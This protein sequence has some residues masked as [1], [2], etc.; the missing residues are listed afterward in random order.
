[1]RCSTL[2][3]LGALL[4]CALVYTM[5]G[6]PS[7]RAQAVGAIVGAVTD[8]TGAVIVGAKVNAVN[9]GTNA[10]SSTQTDGVGRYV[11]DHLNP[12]VYSLEITAA[13][14]G[15]FKH[16]H[17]I[18]EVGR[19]T[20]IEATLK[21]A[22][23]ESTVTTTAEAP[24]VQ[25]DRSDF[26]TNI[27]AATM[28]NSAVNAR[29]WST[30]ALGTPGASP[31]GT[32]GLISFRGISGLLNNNTVDGGDNNQAFF[33]EE[34][35]R[36]RISYSISSAAIQEFQVNTSNYS[37]EYGRAAGG[38]VNAVTK[39]GTNS[40]HGEA[41]WYYRDSDIGATNPFTTQTIL[42]NGVN[43][44]VPIKPPDRR[45]QFGG[46][47]G[48][49]IFK[50]KLFFFF[51]ADQQLRNF[52]G[53]AAPSNPG[54]FFAPLSSSEVSTLTSRGITAAQGN[55]V[56]TGFLNTL[57]GNV[58]RKGDELLLFPKLD[59]NINEKNHA[60][61]EYNR[62]RWSSPAGIQTA[63]V[64]FRGVES[65]GDDFVKID[66]LVARLS[67]TLSP[68]MVNEFR[69]SY[70]RDF[71]YE[72]SQPSIAGEPVSQFGVSPQIS[73]F[74]ASGFTFGKPNFLDRA[75][76]PD[77]RSV[78][79]ADT[80]S[81]SRGRHLF[82]FG[83]D[84]RHTDDLLDN[85]FQNAGV[86]NYNNRVDYISDYIAFTTSHAPFC[87][88]TGCYSSFNQAFGPSAFEFATWDVGF[89]AN[90]DWRVSPRLTLTLGLRYDYQKFPSPQVP[91]TNLPAS[92]QF[93]SDTLNFGPRVGLAWNIT[94]DGKTVLRGGYGITYG[95]VINSTISNAITNTGNTAGQLQF[96]FS[97]PT[98]ANAPVYPNVVPTAPPP[99]AAPPDVV[100]FAPDT[101][102]PM[103]HEFD[104][105][106]EREIARNTAVSV[107]Y[108]GSLG[109]HLPLF[110]D[111]NLPAPASTITYKVLGGPSDQQMFT[112][113]LF[114][115]SRP[116]VGV[117]ASFGR[118]T[119]ISDIVSSRY[120]ALAFQFTRRMTHGLQVQAQYTYSHAHDNG[121]SSQ[122]FT[123]PNNVF[124]PYDLGLEEGRSNF[125]V[126]NHFA[127]SAIWQPEIV[128]SDSKVMKLLA[129]GFTFSPTFSASSGF[130]YTG[131]V[132]GNAPLGGISTG[133]IRAGG[134]ARVPFEP[135]N[136][137]QSPGSFN[138]DFR[139]G[140]KFAITERASFELLTDFFNLL[141][142]VNPTSLNG[143][144]GGSG[145]EY[146]T[147][148]CTAAIT[149]CGTYTGPALQYQSSFG[150]INNTSSSLG[151]PGQ[152]QIQIGARLTW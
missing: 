134:T 21:P 48:G 32:F 82:K 19:S 122:T 24:V 33:A 143:I 53:V 43:T 117:T 65:F 11:I 51:N 128:H 139:V 15:S 121:Q 56:L 150:T 79:F 22:A 2:R 5:A 20:S 41:F 85:L 96:T 55:A 87:A 147:T 60:S 83:A 110:I 71:E 109:R 62:M 81:V 1:M 17:V 98:A 137:F 142:R 102:I 145:S 136:G 149:G 138:I 111:T 108:L 101:Q 18:V 57:T 92:S 107:S 118:I 119:N 10:Q 73:I 70:G 46:S 100:V 66:T 3:S 133:I 54:A 75:A 4:L 72:T 103:V 89:F 63:A 69:F 112:M 42:V 84:I 129:N 6:V 114:T 30:F 26:S 116:N 59:W 39:S 28:D 58:P 93:P 64:V 141:N 77:E 113:P 115:G 67:S 152:R 88:G 146:G 94:G 12:G 97:S 25:T 16:S 131:F 127:A 34:K 36:T 123:S 91:N 76:Y 38:V 50:D 8:Q 120:N 49:P 130:P 132:S 68:R 135:R 104:V 35:G 80:L 47:I 9:L 99:S 13:G 61:V 29:R 144:Q 7:A 86:Y 40:L 37:A 23:T 151:G 45:H 14:F 124:N 78:Q 74:G 125:D 90:D 140:K 105:V 27:N 44:V 95:R 106:F 148:T 52:P 126:R 31:D